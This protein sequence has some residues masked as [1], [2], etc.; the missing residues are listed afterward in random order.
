MKKGGDRD[1]QSYR[2]FQGIISRIDYEFG[3]GNKNTLF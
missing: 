1:K 2:I 3:S